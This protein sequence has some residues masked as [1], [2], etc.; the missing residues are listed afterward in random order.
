MSAGNPRWPQKSILCLAGIEPDLD[1]NAD[2]QNQ[3]SDPAF[4]IGRG[5][6]PKTG[7]TFRHASLMPENIHFGLGFLALQRIGALVDV[8]PALQEVGHL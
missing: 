2:S 1:Q 3:R 8:L 7:S 6:S 4:L 5:V